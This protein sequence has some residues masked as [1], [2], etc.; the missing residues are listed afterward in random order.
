MLSGTGELSKAEAELRTALAMQQKLVD[1]NPAVTGFRQSLAMIGTNLGSLLRDMG[2]SSPAEAEYR[3]A[4]PIWQKLADDNPSVTEFQNGLARSHNE[5]GWLLSNTGKS[6]EAEAEYRKALALYQKLADDNP[7]VT[8]F[9]S[10]LAETP[11]LH[12][13]AARA[14]RKNGRGHRLLHAGRGDPPEAG[15]GQLG[16]PL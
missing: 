16:N 9:R 8:D 1:D 13:L 4:L 6:L 3:K 10:S 12:R 11:G 15:Q 7:A 2:K 5:L 14:G